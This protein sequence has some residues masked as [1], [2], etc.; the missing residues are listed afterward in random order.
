MGRHQIEI[1]VVGNDTNQFDQASTPQEISHQFICDIK[2]GYL[3]SRNFLEFSGSVM[4]CHRLIERNLRRVD[5]PKGC[6]LF[7]DGQE[8][9]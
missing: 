5:Y 1:E 9:S 3:R 6:L 8:E 2:L 7:W 4:C